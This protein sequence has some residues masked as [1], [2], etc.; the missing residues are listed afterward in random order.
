VGHLELVE[1]IESATA[2]LDGLELAGNAYHGVGIPA[3]IH[4]GEQ[5]AQRVLRVC[6]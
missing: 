4:S 6:S 5:A 3:C 1:R 2:R